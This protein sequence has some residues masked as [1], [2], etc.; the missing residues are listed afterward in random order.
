MGWG[1][2]RD[3]SW[4]SGD[5]K[6]GWGKGDKRSSACFCQECGEIRGVGEFGNS[7]EKSIFGFG[8]DGK[9]IFEWYFRG[10]VSSRK[11]FM[12]FYQTNEIFL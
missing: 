10:W 3:K 1:E 12:F 4:V 9:D 7:I 6:S 2:N 8:D 11:K 5:G